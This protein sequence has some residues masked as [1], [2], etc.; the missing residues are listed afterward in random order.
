[1]NE[2]LVRLSED[3]TPGACAH[4]WHEAMNLAKAIARQATAFPE[5]FRGV[6]ESS[7][8][9]PSLRARSSKFTC[10][11]EAIAKAIHL[12]EKHAAADI[13]DNRSRIG[14]LCHFMVAQMVEAVESAR[15]EKENFVRTARH[16]G[17]ES[18][19]IIPSCFHP[20][21][22]TFL[23]ECWKLPELRGHAKEWW[24]GRIREMVKREHN[25]MEKN[26][27]HHPALWHELGK[28]TDTGTAKARW[29]ALEKYCLNKLK[30][31]AGT[32]PVT[33]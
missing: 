13:H 20:D 29:R 28:V 9:M 1:M 27:T 11:G 30:Q 23:Q 18:S 12:G 14:A 16:L 21:Q 25:R 32:S 6:A 5:D 19:D 26:T 33:A 15:R 2:Q 4:L 10:D 8:T 7:L 24:E 22:R 31:I 3:R 17:K